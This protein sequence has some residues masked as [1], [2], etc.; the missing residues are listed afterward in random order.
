MK[1]DQAI[2][3]EQIADICYFMKGAIEW[4]TAWGISFAEREVI[5]KIINK[6]L[7]EQNPNGKE[8]M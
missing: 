7:R 4:N 3:H 1:K 5:V 6:R 2:L 8:Y